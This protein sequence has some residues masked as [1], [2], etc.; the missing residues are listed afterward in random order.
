M[1]QA[2][3]LLLSLLFVAFPAQ[4][5]AYT[6]NE[7]VRNDGIIYQVI[8]V[9]ANK[10]SFV[11]VED[12][13]SGPVTIPA[14][15]SDGKGVT[16]TVTK[17]GGNETFYCRNITAVTLPE[18][19]TEI[20]YSSFRSAYLTALNIPASVTKIADNVFYRVNKMPWITVDPGNTSFSDDGHGALY[21]NDKTELFAVPSNPDNLSPDGT[22]TVNTAVKTIHSAVFI[23][24][25]GMKKMV[26]PPNLQH[27]RTTYPS[28][29]QTNSLEAY[30]IA[31]GGLTP[32]TVNAGVLFLNQA[33]VQYPRNKPTKDYVVPNGITEITGRA[34]DMAQKMESI[35]MNQ[36]T[37]LGEN[38]INACP[39]LKTVT[40]PK[41][42]QIPGTV[43]AISSCVQI[44]EYKTAP[45]CVNFIAE[46]GVVYSKPNKELL[47][48]FPPAKPIADGNYAIPSFVKTVGDFAFSSNRYIKHLTIPGNVEIIKK[49]AFG[50]F[51]EL[52]TVTFEEPSS[53]STIGSGAFGWNPKLQEVT[54]PSTLTELNLIF[55][56]CKALETINI[57]AN[58]KLKTIKKGV[59]QTVSNLKHFNF[60]GACDLETIEDGAFQDL[61]FLES[62]AFPKGVKTIGTNAFQRCERMK[63]ATFDDD[64]VITTIKAGALADCGLT[65]I[66]I[67]NSVKTLEK[68]AF[69]GCAALTEVNLSKNVESISSE[70]FKY[71]ENLTDINVHKENTKYSSIDG[72][73]LSKDKLT[74]IL[75]PHGK[76]NDHFTLLPP[77]ITMIGDYAFYECTGL[78]NVVIP[79]KVASIGERAFSL[80]K[81]LNTITFLCDL[82][83][84]PANIN[85]EDNKRSFDNGSSGTTN[86]P[87]NID[88]YVRKN[89]LD[90]YNASTFY[91][92]FKSRNTSFTENHLEYM[93]VSDNS[94]DLLDVRSTDY[95]FIVPETVTH[96]GKTYSVNLIGDYAFQNTTNAVQ[97]VVVKKNVE[98]IGAKAFKTDIN[99]NASTIRN[100]FFL[101]SNPTK[102]ML[103]TTRFELDETNDDYNEFAPTTKIYV[104]KSALPTY[105]TQWHK[106]VYDLGTHGYQESQFNF[107]G[108]LSY[109]IP[110]IEITHKYGSFA[111]E[112]DTDLSVYKTEKGNGDMGA[113]VAKV[114]EVKEGPGDYGNATY[115]VKMTSVDMNGGY[116][117]SYGYVPAFTGVLLKVLDLNATPA[118]FYYAIGEHD[119]VTYNVTNNIMHGITVNS[120]TVAASMTDPIYVM[121]KNSGIFKRRT[122]PLPNFP[123]HKAYAKIPGM[124]AG[125]KIQFITDD[126]ELTPTGI[127]VADGPD[128]KQDEDAACYNLYGQR[129]EKPTRGVYIHQGKKIIVK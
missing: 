123:V 70:T 21:T 43:G 108:Q 129:I 68:E 50:G 90:N 13:V 75:F 128:T 63:T 12:N 10:L 49:Q 4:L 42:L 39:I 57:A 114:G 61:K 78:K 27:A 105:Q 46:D 92:Q 95:T 28:F 89:L 82:M 34:I 91:Q 64:A 65:A 62:F 79:N 107:T 52:L 84:D 5:L 25:N 41:D 100:V 22:Y 119:D 36:V 69:R 23:N 2:K 56:D 103:S 54:L 38:S 109:Q 55:T 116:A 6:L 93:P 15:W 53:T 76:A 115:M 106:Q 60:L 9:G 111:R 113:F 97:E 101:A 74:L 126:E 87:A 121:S 104:K 3:Q 31:P 24:T 122:S 48:F 110:G 80:C 127:E 40:L 94:V 118:D 125:A 1:K 71:C 30:G 19:I 120:Q 44:K 11:G 85:Q 112:F 16:F 58:S 17:V 77:S 88:I 83:I 20:A 29:S 59:L 18:G 37:K 32:Y 86:M 26:L 72:Y 99:A 96:A 35:V 51:S 102:Q 47:Y 117:G 33:L 66:S 7:I 98:Y 67:P 8:D 81:N 45:G 73:L 14:T 124:P